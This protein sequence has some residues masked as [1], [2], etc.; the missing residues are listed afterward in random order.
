M[1][2]S[3]RSK[4]LPLFPVGVGAVLSVT[5]AASIAGLVALAS[6]QAAQA[7]KSGH[8]M[9]AG[10]RGSTTGTAGRGDSNP[11]VR[12]HRGGA[13]GGGVTVKDG[14]PRPGGLCAGWFC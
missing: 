12:D 8:A 11:V 2:T 5:T 7:G 14:K 4:K 1:S 3:I 13:G 10:V 6:P 9:S